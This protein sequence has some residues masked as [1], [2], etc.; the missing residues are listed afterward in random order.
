MKFTAALISLLPFS[1]MA[2]WN[3]V[4]CEGKLGAKLVRAEVER[5]LSGGPI[6][7]PAKLIVRDGDMEEIH[8]Y[9]VTI[10]RPGGFNQ[11]EYSDF[12]FRLEVDLSPHT[13]P[14]FGWSY[15]GALFSKVLGG[16]YL[17]NLRCRFPNAY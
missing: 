4:E 11:I 16:Q 12:G 17:K 13:Y 3:E 9:A 5:E 6:F 2:S 15:K 14:R 8:D 1:A 10:R 7:R